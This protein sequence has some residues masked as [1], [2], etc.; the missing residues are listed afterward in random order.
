M[1]QNASC[2]VTKKAHINCLLQRLKILL[3]PSVKE[4]LQH[5]IKNDG[6]VDDK[7]DFSENQQGEN[8]ELEGFKIATLSNDKIIAVKEDL[9]QIN[10]CKIRSA[11]SGFPTYKHV[12]ELEAQGTSQEVF[13]G[14]EH[15]LSSSL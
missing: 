8:V 2:R 12:N 9:S 15:S 3:R 6:E 10:L 1:C 5:G 13:N 14:I 7:M 4:A 11:Q